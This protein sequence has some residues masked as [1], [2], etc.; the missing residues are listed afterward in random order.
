M[1]TRAIAKYVRISPR[2]VHFIANEIRG[3]KV[4]D[5]LAF[6]M[7]T[8]KHGARVLYDVLKSAVANAENNFDADREKLY[9]K[10][11][12][13]NDGPRMKRYRPKAKG[14]AYPIIKRTS[15]IG[16]VVADE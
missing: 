14:M 10:D 1:E 13:A 11:A 15:H 2:K 3:K 5:A 9:V 6:L 16:V 7:F 8:P 12:Y 4:D